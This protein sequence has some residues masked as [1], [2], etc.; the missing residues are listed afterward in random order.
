MLKFNFEFNKL[1]NLILKLI[2][3]NKEYENDIISNDISDYFKNDKRTFKE[4]ENE[5]PY[6][7][8]KKIMIFIQTKNKFK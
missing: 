8:K 7:N 1:E 6:P 2:N 4:L 5:I 3:D